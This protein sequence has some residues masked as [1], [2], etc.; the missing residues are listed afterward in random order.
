MHTFTPVLFVLMILGPGAASAGDVPVKLD[1]DVRYRHDTL[2]IDGEEVNHRHRLRLRFGALAE[3]SEQL[4]VG[5]QLATGDGDPVSLN[6]T[7]SPAF[8]KK[9]VNVNLGYLQYRPIEGLSILAGKMK[10]PFY[11]PGDSQLVWDSDLT[12]EGLSASYARQ[13]SKVKVFATGVAFWTEDRRD[14]EPD[15]H[16]VGGQGGAGFKLGDFLL[17]VSGAF[18]N[19]TRLVGHSPLFEDDAFGNT[20]DA[21]NLYVEDYN[22]LEAG[23]ELLGELWKLPFSVYGNFAHNL[24]ADQERTAF[25]AGFTVGEAKKPKTWRVGYNYR[26]V[27]RDAVFGTFSD[28]DFGGGGTGTFGH[29][30][31]GAFALNGNLSFGL[32]LFLSELDD[33]DHTAYRRIQLDMIAK[34]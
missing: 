8:T 5:F 26:V 17:V 34:F 12:P 13:F 14:G 23:V 33:A 24:G 22:L 7:L 27:Q 15:A 30:I 16:L 29:L 32:T 6:Q 9:P 3:I 18:Y 10:N 25:L 2:K 4:E 31:T 20:V 11:R 28:S 1:G 19:Y 21:T